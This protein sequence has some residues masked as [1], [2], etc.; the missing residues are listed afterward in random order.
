MEGYEVICTIGPSTKDIAILK[1]L[2]AAGADIFRVNMSHASIKELKEIIS[3]TKDLEIKIGIDT[4]GAQIRTK[5]LTNSNINLEKG[6]ILKVFKNDINKINTLSFYPECIFPFLSQDDLLRID[7]NGAVAKVISN[8]DELIILECVNPGKIGNNKGVDIINKAINIPDFT[9]KDL[10]ALKIASKNNISEIFI[11]FCKSPEAV[12]KARLIVPEARIT[13]KIESKLSIHNLSKICKVTDAT[14]IDRGDL[15]R[16][17]NIMDIPFAQRGIV[18]ISNENNT[19]CFVATNVLESLIE[20][21]LPTRAELNDIVGTLEMGASGIVLAAETA[22]GKKPLL[23]VEIVKELMHRYKL[24]KS[25]LL[26]ADIERREITDKEMR[27]W[28]NR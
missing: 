2:K 27:I 7:F 19:P 12:Q 20:G 24:Y 28:L 10:E 17:I 18:N 9:P 26:F 3:M 4:E 5:L 16:E 21:D 6:E 14:L 22:I 13:S 15:T 11:S 25:G 8:K 1:K 23:C